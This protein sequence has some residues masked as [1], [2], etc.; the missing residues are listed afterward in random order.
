MWGTCH[1][2]PIQKKF[3]ASLPFSPA[4]C[5]S[6]FSRDFFSFEPVSSFFPLSYGF[7]RQGKYEVI[8]TFVVDFMAGQMLLFV[9]GWSV[10]VSAD[11]AGS[12]R[13]RNFGWQSKHRLSRNTAANAR[14]KFHFPSF[15]HFV[16][17]SLFFAASVSLFTRSALYLALCTLFRGRVGH[18]E[19]REWNSR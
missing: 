17:F 8:R 7:F 16:P 10:R 6:Q 5:F 2:S 9:L 1:F 15:S 18:T 12:F 11:S 4:V 13:K 3:P 19:I 14:M